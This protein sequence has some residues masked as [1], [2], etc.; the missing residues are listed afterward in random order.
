MKLPAMLYELSGESV[1]SKP[2]SQEY[3]DSLGSTIYY[4][5]LQALI[6]LDAKSIQVSLVQTLFYRHFCLDTLKFNVLTEECLLVIYTA[7]RRQ[8]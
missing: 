2:L 6:I 8:G 3:L 1:F 7:R 5:F 4:E